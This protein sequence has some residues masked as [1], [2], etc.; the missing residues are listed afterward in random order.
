MALSEAED[1]RSNRQRASTDCSGLCD[2]SSLSSFNHLLHLFSLQSVKLDCDRIYS[3][4]GIAHSLVVEHINVDYRISTS[5]VYMDLAVKSM[6]H[7]CNLDYLNSV[8]YSEDTTLEGLPS[9]VPN[10]TNAPKV[11]PKG[12]KWMDHRL[13]RASGPQPIHEP[14]RISGKKLL[15]K[16]RL[17]DVIGSQRMNV[18]NRGADISGWDVDLDSRLFEEAAFY[19]LIENAIDACQPYRT[20]ETTMTIMCRL[21]SRDGLRRPFY[22]GPTIE[23][24]QKAFRDLREHARYRRELLQKSQELGR[25]MAMRIW[26][27]SHP[28]PLPT[29][30]LCWPITR[31]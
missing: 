22:D 2:P 4:L 28:D 23:D 13:F 20:R 3:L 17:I 11:K 12:I 24:F 21:L 16:A 19:G 7:D 26:E 15:V 8:E 25:S 9:W 18:P 30:V 29:I 6:K 1:W 27:L 31:I 14:F 10:W 5:Q